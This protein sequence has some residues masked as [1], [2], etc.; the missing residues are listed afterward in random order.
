MAREA[1]QV[2]VVD[3][4]DHEQDIEV[5]RREL[6]GPRLDEQALVRHA[7]GKV[8]QTGPVGTERPLVER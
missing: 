5:E 3:R 7:F 6:R 4:A 1:V 8:G 2:F